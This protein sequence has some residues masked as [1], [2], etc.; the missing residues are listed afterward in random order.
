M[1]DAA[2]GAGQDPGEGA[3]G[4]PVGVGVPTAGHGAA[5]GAGE[6]PVGVGEGRGDQGGVG[7]GVDPVVV[8]V[9]G[10][11]PVRDAVEVGPRLLLG[12]PDP[13]A[14]GFGEAGAGRY[15]GQ[16]GPERGVDVGPAGGGLGGGGGD[17]EG[18]VDPV[19]GVG[20]DGVAVGLGGGGDRVARIGPA[21]D[22]GP[23]EGAD[24]LAE[25]VVVGGGE[26]GLQAVEEIAVRDALGGEG[27]AGR[28]LVEPEAADVGGGEALA[29][30]LEE[31]QAE[32]GVVE[33][34]VLGHAVDV[35]GEGGGG[36]AAVP[37][38]GGQYL[39][40]DAAFGEPVVQGPVAGGQGQGPDP[41]E[42]QLLDGL[43]EQTA[44]GPPQPG[45][46]QPGLRGGLRL[47][48]SGRGGWGWPGGLDGSPGGGLGGGEGEGSRARSSRRRIARA[49]SSGGAGV[50]EAPARSGAGWPP[51]AAQA[52]R[53]ASA[54]RPS[55]A[56]CR[57]SC[58]TRSSGCTQVTR[59][60]PPIPAGGT[61]GSAVGSGGA[62][63]GG[64]GVIGGS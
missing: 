57:S 43:P 46:F 64:G 60:R 42:R 32:E 4:G 30:A 37:G 20:E 12:G 63:C 61:V 3:G 28:E 14:D 40:G 35:L 17:E 48:G 41:V 9:A 38:V 52:R 44:D 27:P 1:R 23:D 26:R 54:S 53:A 31:E 7:E 34:V 39:R 56:A 2:R 49:R 45:G 24:P 8:A 25:G 50:G 62:A 11:Q 6:V 47:G 55:S 10:V 51:A 59:N 16:A 18:G 5:D 13:E 58:P 21:V 36:G 29:V 19:G 15:D 22:I 33:V